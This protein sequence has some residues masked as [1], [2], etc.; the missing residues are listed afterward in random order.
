M[1]L[2][3]TRKGSDPFKKYWW[4]VLLVFL[5]MGAWTFF[6]ALGGGGSALGSNQFFL[7]AGALKPLDQSLDVLDASAVGASAPGN[8]LGKGAAG[9]GSGGGMTDPGSM[10]YQ[11]LGAG[12]ASASAAPRNLADALG[13]ISRRP[14]GART[15]AEAPG[16][17]ASY[18]IPSATFAPIAGGMGSGGSSAGSFTVPEGR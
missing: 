12:N 18:S 3:I 2:T 11:P 14:G 10:L 16:S 15:P 8:A 1:A 7:N 13:A 6:P 9:A 17:A 5:L 4:V